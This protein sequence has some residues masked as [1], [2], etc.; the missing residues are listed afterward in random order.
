[1]SLERE[2]KLL[3]AQT[4]TYFGLVVIKGVQWVA[5]WKAFGFASKGWKRLN[6]E[7]IAY[8]STRRESALTRLAGWTIQKRS[9]LRAHT[10][11]VS[12]EKS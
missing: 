3:R 7:G 4:R 6:T 2:K 8:L 11:L 12:G 10:T 5:G 1:L 9:S